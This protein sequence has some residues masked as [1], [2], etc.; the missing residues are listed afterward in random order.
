MTNPY[1]GKVVGTCPDLEAE[2]AAD[3]VEAAQT[4]FQPFRHTPARQRATILQKWH[5]LIKEHEQDLATILTYENG[6]P[7]DAAKAEIQYAAS[8][9]GWFQGEA[10]RA[11]SGETIESSAPGQRVLTFKQP[12]GVVGVL[13]PC[14]FPSAMITRKVGAALAAGCSVVVKPAAETPYSA[15]ALAEL[16]ERAGVPAGVFNVVTTHAHLA[17][18]GKTL[19]EHDI[20]KKGLVYGLDAGGQ[21]ADGAVSLDPQ[22]AVDGARRQC[23]LYYL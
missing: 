14:S 5:D 2:D 1:D 19:C 12:V 3:A 7:L 17:E 21:A 10:L 8:F 11:Y 22:E 4:A 6:R 15:L 13:T 18:V 9:F 20:V 16:G 23:S